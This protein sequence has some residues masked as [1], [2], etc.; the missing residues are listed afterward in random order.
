MIT[1]SLLIVT[2]IFVFIIFIYVLKKKHIESFG[3]VGDVIRTV[4]KTATT[5][6]KKATNVAKKNHIQILEKNY[7][8]K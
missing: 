6:A 7:K 1:S 2:L 5:V 8:H 4:K 3:Y